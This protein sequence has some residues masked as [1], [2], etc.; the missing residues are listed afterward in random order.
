VKEQGVHVDP[1]KIQFI[2]YWLALKKMTELRS[3]L[4][5]TNFYQWFVMGFSHIAWA[6]IQ[7]TKGGVKAKFAW[8][9]PQQKSFEDLKFL[10]LLNTTPHSS[11]PA[12]TI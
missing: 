1:T 10:P 9:M 4:G 7:V 12:T 11:K 2:H 5:L 3:F 6:L 8:S